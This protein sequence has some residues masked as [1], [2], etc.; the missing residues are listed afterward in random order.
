[1]RA[2]VHERAQVH[3]CTKLQKYMRAQ[4]HEG[5]STKVHKYIKT[6]QFIPPL[7]CY[8]VCQPST[9]CRVGGLTELAVG[10]TAGGAT[11]VVRE[12]GAQ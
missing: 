8:Q 7:W 12:R 4:A 10:G 6:T 3:D 11:R 9:V 2:Q 5:T 1:M